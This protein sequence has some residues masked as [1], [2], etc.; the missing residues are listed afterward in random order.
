MASSEF[1]RLFGE[2]EWP[3]AFTCH[4]RIGA[5]IPI[6]G[7][8]MS[9]PREIPITDRNGTIHECVAES[10]STTHHVFVLI[11]AASALTST[12]VVLP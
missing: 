9:W 3:D 7:K 12:S 2:I 6:G 1:E 10:F 11:H 5:M 8:R 4:D